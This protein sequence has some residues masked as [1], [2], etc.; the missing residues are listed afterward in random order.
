VKVISFSLFGTDPTYTAGALVNA[1]LAREVYP[2]WTC[3]FYVGSSIKLDVISGLEAAGAQVIDRSDWPQDWSALLWRYDT[4]TDPDIEA[5]LFRDCDSRLSLREASAVAEWLDSGADF[6]IIRDHPEHYM[7][8]MAGMWGAT[9]A[10]RN[11]SPTPSRP[12]SV[13]TGLSTRC[14]CATSSTR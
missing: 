14:G 6:H 5:H 2:G 8:I 3:R 12:A 9:A 7:P 10:G 11:S 4:L 13:I 1:Q